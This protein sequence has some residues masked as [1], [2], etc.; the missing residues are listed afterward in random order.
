MGMGPCH[1][2]CSH[3]SGWGWFVDAWLLNKLDTHLPAARP[4]PRRLL[5]AAWR[6]W[7]TWIL[8]ML[9]ALCKAWTLSARWWSS[10]GAPGACVWGH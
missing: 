3:A 4:P 2:C 9:C 7:Q 6:S 5:G 10:S 1:A 8:W